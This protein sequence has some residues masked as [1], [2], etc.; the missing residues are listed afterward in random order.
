[1]GPADGVTSDVGSA[2]PPATHLT[3]AEE[4]QCRKSTVPAREMFGS[5]QAKDAG[6]D[7]PAQARIRRRRQLTTNLAENV[8]H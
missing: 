3:W 7:Q 6:L 1:M 2:A 5:A 8:S 4:G